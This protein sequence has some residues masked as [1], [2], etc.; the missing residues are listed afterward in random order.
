MARQRKESLEEQEEKSGEVQQMGASDACLGDWHWNEGVGWVEQ[1]SVLGTQ[2][3][4]GQAYESVQ[5]QFPL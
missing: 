3:T 4:Y 5:E 2:H 1:L